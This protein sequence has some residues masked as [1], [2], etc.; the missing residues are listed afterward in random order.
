MSDED[1][2]VGEIPDRPWIT[3]AEALSLRAFGLASEAGVLK[4]VIYQL[5]KP[6]EI[7][8]RLCLTEATQDSRCAPFAR[9][10]YEVENSRWNGRRGRLTD[11]E[12]VKAAL[13][14][15]P[16]AH[17]PPSAQEFLSH[18]D[19]DREFCLRLFKA[20]TE[21]WEEAYAERAQLR[22][23]RC[24]PEPSR[25]RDRVRGLRHPLPQL[26]EVEFITSHFFRTPPVYDP[27]S[28]RVVPGRKHP[29]GAPAFYGVEVAREGVVR[30]LG[31]DRACS[32]SSRAPEFAVQS[33]GDSGS[34]RCSE[35]LHDLVASD[36]RGLGRP[37]GI[38]GCI[39]DPAILK[40]AKK[41]MADCRSK[42]AAIL[43][44][45]DAVPAARGQ[46]Y[47]DERVYN[48]INKKWGNN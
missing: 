46:S 32:D 25:S 7:T 3:V 8:R 4:K 15:T 35:G 38:L 16:A 21:L 26:G 41:L 28:D 12:A 27:W 34:D 9:R 20:S 44:G 22:G 23:Q 17:W 45:R 19:A 2:A 33:V 40:K 5:L 39:H 31:L 11:G 29:A 47:T 18:F 37:P 14:N 36:R 10:L 6:M 43:K 13:D 24:S 30:W 1:G 42:R 48:R